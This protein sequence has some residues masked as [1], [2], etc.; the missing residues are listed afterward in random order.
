M[1]YPFSSIKKSWMKCEQ[2]PFTFI[3]EKSGF[4]LSTLLTIQLLA[5]IFMMIH[6]YYDVMSKKLVLVKS[7]MEKI[8]LL[9]RTRTKRA[10][11]FWTRIKNT[12]NTIS[13]VAMLR[14]LRSACKLKNFM[15]CAFSNPMI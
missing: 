15:H 7:T 11:K 2:E 14:Q 1:R 4:L 3:V 5:D 9:E 13:I 12:V 10:K 6:T 8:R